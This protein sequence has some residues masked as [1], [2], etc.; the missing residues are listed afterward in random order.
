MISL[1]AIIDELGGLGQNNQLLCHLPADLRHFKTITQGKPVI[2]GRKTFEAIGKLLPGRTNI[3]LSRQCLQIPEAHIYST[4][5][6]ALA[7]VRDVI[8]VMVIGGATVYQQAL[9][10]ADR[11]YLT[12]IHHT[13]PADVFFP[14]MAATEW[15]CVERIFR[16]KDDKNFYDMTFC[17]YEKVGPII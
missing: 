4:L 13:F 2:M 5:E 17:T 6:Q 3:I 15:Q 1:I 14:K 8:E 10:L 16:P 11:V 9:S 7:S 12:E